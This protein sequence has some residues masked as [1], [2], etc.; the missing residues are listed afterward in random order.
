MLQRA[1]RLLGKREYPSFEIVIEV[2]C[3]K[4]ATFV[5]VKL[6]GSSRPRVD[7]VFAATLGS[8]TLG[9]GRVPMY[10]DILV[11]EEV[12]SRHSLV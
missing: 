8:S 10:G 9:F 7:L 4:P 1:I 5:R 6:A 12:G 2:L 11:L 3:S